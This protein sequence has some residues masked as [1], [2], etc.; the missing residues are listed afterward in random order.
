VLGFLRQP[1]LRVLRPAT[2]QGKSVV[3]KKFASLLIAVGAMFVSRA[4]ANP[5][6]DQA[7][8]QAIFSAWTQAFNEKRFPAVCDL[9]SKALTADYQGAPSKDYSS[10][11]SGFEKIFLEKGVAYHNDF[12]I[13]QIVRADNVAAV[14]ITWYLDVYKEGAHF[15]SV[16]EEGL[17]V[18]R[19]QENGKWEIVNFIA[20][21]VTPEK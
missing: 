15:S 8:F 4:H 6:E 18:F 21:P 9:F 12:R 3:K 2:S 5:A 16:Q 13:H 10:I 19:Q 14:R 7:T 11:C 17:D 20:Y 1:N